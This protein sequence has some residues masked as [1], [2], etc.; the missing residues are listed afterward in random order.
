MCPRNGGALRTH[1]TDYCCGEG[2]QR[3]RLSTCCACAVLSL[4]ATYCA[5]A[6]L[7]LALLRLRGAVA[8]AL[9]RFAVSVNVNNS[10]VTLPSH[11]G[12]SPVRSVFSGTT[13]PGGA[14]RLSS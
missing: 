6:V 11:R 7:S 5:C 1:R 3:L 9:L 13:D 8:C 14:L 10:W 12:L 4:V 2:C